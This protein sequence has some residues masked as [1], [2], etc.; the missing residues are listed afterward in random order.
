MTDTNRNSNDAATPHA[1][2]QQARPMHVTPVHIRTNSASPRPHRRHE[3][4]SPISYDEPTGRRHEAP[5]HRDPTRQDGADHEGSAVASATRR[6]RQA[7]RE[8]ARA[9]L[10]VEDKISTLAGDAKGVL[11]A[12]RRPSF[13][14]DAEDAQGSSAADAAGAANAASSSRA[15][16]ASRVKGAAK[17]L[18]GLR[19]VERDRGPSPRATRV[20]LG[21]AGC[22]V[23]VGALGWCYATMW[24]QIGVTVNDQAE[25]VKVGTTLEELL[26]SKDYYGVAPGRLLSVG[27]NVL[28]EQGGTRCTVTVG[29]DA[30]DASKLA[31]TPVKEG[32]TVTVEAGADVTEDYTAEEV[33]IAPGIQMGRGGAIQ[34]VSQW[35]RA[36]KKTVWHGSKSGETVDH[37]V[38]AEPQDMI[39]ESVNVHPQGDKKYIALT[40]DDGPS[41][42]TQAIL[43]ILK[44]K[45]A[46]ATFYNLGQASAASP[47]LS[48]AVVDGGHELASHTNRH[49]NLPTLDRDALREEITSAF[50]TLE[51]SSGKR[52]QMIRAPYGAFTATEWARSGDL[53]SCNVL[54]NIDTLDWK[55][56]GA[57]AITS[58][59]LSHAFN[60]AIAL[61]HDGGGNRSQDVEALPGIIDGL[62]A[63]GYELVTVSELMQT[64]PSIPKDVA[65]GTVKVPKDAALPEM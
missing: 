14:D 53:I 41:P 9:A 4:G 20:M 8:G 16:V 7:L 5:S 2:R 22:L 51:Q 54:W 26:K 44:E 64:D 43:D 3:T 19:R 45:G 61:M 21:L 13:M 49:Q 18:S 27:G 47:D 50:D 55:R 60:G 59:V 37:E 39:V 52:L 30:V 12:A 28:D 36:G 35:G 29:G 32:S 10:P 17:R 1:E 40:F 57:Q 46:K 25:Q 23:L 38:T 34:Y 48:R 15:A 63:A 42:Y 58:Q 56:P 65:S 24:R 62:K 31:E 6:A 11:S 33:P